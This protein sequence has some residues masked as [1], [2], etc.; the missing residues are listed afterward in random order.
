M[1]E[2]EDVRATAFHEAGHAVIGYWLKL[3]LRSATIVAN[4]NYLGMVR[5]SIRTDMTDVDSLVQNRQRLFMERQIMF[6]LAG[7]LA[8]SMHLGRDAES[9][10]GQDFDSAVSA[11]DWMS[12]STEEAEAY[13][14]WLGERTR[15]I[16]R[17][18]PVWDAVTAV[19][20]AL[21]EHGTLGQ[22]RLR[23]IIEAA[24]FPDRQPKDVDAEA[25][26]AST[27]AP[28]SPWIPGSTASRL[29]H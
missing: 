6:S 9:G 13:V 23:Q 28:I 26:A 11:A 14:H 17:L 22:N 20:D 10:F 7:E 8:E 25:D 29:R 27:S 16:L 21:M 5:S 12:A 3:G 15:T 1:G 19:A 2:A 18:E 24:M 4:A